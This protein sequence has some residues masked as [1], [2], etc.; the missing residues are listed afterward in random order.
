MLA[1]DGAHLGLVVNAAEKRTPSRQTRSKA[2]VLTKAASWAPMCEASSAMAKR[3][4]AIESVGQ[5]EA[6]VDDF[7]LKRLALTL[8]AS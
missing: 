1:R 6:V 3:M 5:E 8:E 7:V 2:G 4:L